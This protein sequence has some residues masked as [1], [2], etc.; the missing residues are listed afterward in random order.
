MKITLI[1][2]SGYVVRYYDENGNKIGYST[3]SEKE[4]YIQ[5]VISYEYN[6]FFRR[7]NKRGRRVLL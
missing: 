2:K 7:R 5:S 6:S 3:C 4:F 1:R